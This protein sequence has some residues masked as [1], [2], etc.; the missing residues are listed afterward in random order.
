MAAR[1]GP[2]I[3]VEAEPFSSICGRRQA[4]RGPCAHAS[5]ACA[6]ATRARTRARGSAAVRRASLSP[7]RRC[8]AADAVCPSRSPIA[9]QVVTLVAVVGVGRLRRRSASWR[10]DPRAQPGRER[11]CRAARRGRR[12]ARRRRP[13][14]GAAST[15]TTS[16]WSPGTRPGEPPL[17]A[18]ELCRRS[19]ARRPTRSAFLAFGTWLTAGVGRPARARASS[20]CA[21]AA[22]PSRSSS[23]PAHGRLHRGARADGRRP[24]GGPLPRPLRRPAGAA[25]SSRRATTLLAA[26]V[27][28]HARACCRAAPMPIWLRDESGQLVWVNAAYAAA[29]EAKDAGRG[30]ARTGSSCSTAPAAQMIAAAHAEPTRSSRGACRRRRRRAAHLRRR[31]HRLGGRQRRHRH[32]RDRGRERPGG[33]PPRGRLQRPHARPARRPPSPSSVPTGGSSSTTPPIARCSASTPPSSIPT[34]DENAVLDRLRAARKLPEQADFRALARRSSWRPTA[35]L[36]AREHWWHLPDGQ[37]L[38]VIANPTS[39]GR[40]DLDLRERHRAARPG[41]PLQRADQRAG[42]DARPP[43]RGRRGV[44]LGRPAPPAQPAFAAIWALDRGAPRR[45]PAR[46]RHRRAPAARPHDDEAMWRRFTASVA[47]LDENRARALGPH[48]ARATSASS[49]TPPCRCPTARRW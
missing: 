32:R 6:A 25:P 33:A 24:R 19:P 36:E 16:G 2:A 45:A 20:A 42:R 10:S 15:T 31:R 12:S 27:E 35:S 41:E 23:R 9:A 28:T 37:T 34:P 8:L 30:R 48:G 47:G 38:R 17:V 14:R 18:G 4:A 49:T 21:S 46:R 13:R 43:Q 29:V 44:R 3:A 5:T 26:E 11:E 40:H 39:A 1:V 7:Q 22:S